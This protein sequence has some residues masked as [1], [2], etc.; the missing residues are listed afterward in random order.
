[1]T[2]THLG[3]EQ[4]KQHDDDDAAAHHNEHNRPRVLLQQARQRQI[5]EGTTCKV[6]FITDHQQPAL[7][8]AVQ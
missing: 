5:E 3:P 4:R 6:A 2:C 8:K 1:M 7:Y